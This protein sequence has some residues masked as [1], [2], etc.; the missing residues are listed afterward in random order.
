M[1]APPVKND[2]ACSAEEQLVRG[3]HVVGRSRF[4]MYIRIGA[5][6]AGGCSA[7]SAIQPNKAA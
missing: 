7:S 4:M 1:L 3:G 6:A 2:I 5:V